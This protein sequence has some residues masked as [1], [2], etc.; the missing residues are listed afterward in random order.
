MITQPVSGSGR[1]IRERC[2]KIKRKKKLTN[3]SFAFTHTY[4]LEKLT[5]FLF[6]PQAYMEN[7]EKC[8]KTQKQYIVCFLKIEL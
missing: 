6:F 7:F 8:A 1:Q 4:T 2:K 3:V 5:F